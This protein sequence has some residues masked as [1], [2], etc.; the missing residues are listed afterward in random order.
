MAVP[1]QPVQP[2]AE[3]LRDPILQDNTL[4]STTITHENTLAYLRVEDTTSLTAQRALS[5]PTPPDH[6]VDIGGHPRLEDVSFSSSAPPSLSNPP[7]LV[8]SADTTADP[9]LEDIAT[10]PVLL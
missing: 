7:P 2:P 4:V 5:S 8:P 3:M 6:L 10:D 9:W 1:E